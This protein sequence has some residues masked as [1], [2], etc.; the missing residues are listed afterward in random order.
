V[1]GGGAVM[2]SEAEG[3][4]KGFAYF[5]SANLPTCCFLTC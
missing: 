3:T 1:G 2:G 5:Q 4:V